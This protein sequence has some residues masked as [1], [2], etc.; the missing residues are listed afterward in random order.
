MRLCVCVFLVQCC[1]VLY[2]TALWDSRWWR[3][4]CVV[5]RVPHQINGATASRGSCRCCCLRRLCDAHR[6]KSV[7][8]I[9]HFKKNDKA[10]LIGIDTILTMKRRR[11]SKKPNQMTLTNWAHFTAVQCT[12]PYTQCWHCVLRMRTSSSSSIAHSNVCWCLIGHNVWHTH[13]V[14][15]F[16]QCQL[17][18]EQQ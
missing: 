12:L 7:K 9:S 1:T 11:K 2:R 17:K 14:H 13:A 8:K 18:I 16:V 5:K 15:T 6:M 10:F 3:V 4:Q